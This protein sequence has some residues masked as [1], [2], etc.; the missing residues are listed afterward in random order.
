M[1]PVTCYTKTKRLSALTPTRIEHFYAIIQNKV[2]FKET[3]ATV[4]LQMTGMRVTKCQF[5]A[6]VFLF[7]FFLMMDDRSYVNTVNT[8]FRPDFPQF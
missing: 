5:D 2:E 1:K 3:F 6:A 8:Q 7:S 4:A